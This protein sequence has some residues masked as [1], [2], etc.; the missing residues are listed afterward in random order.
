MIDIPLA[1]SLH[2]LGTETAFEVLARAKA[3]E[4]E[5][6]RIIHLQIGEPDFDTPPHVVE[7]AAQA[8]RDGHTHYCP[9]PGIPELREA[10]AA[11]LSRTRGIDVA[12]GRV[13]V[14]PGAKPFLFFGVLATCDPGDE[15]IYPN[16]GFPIYESVIRWAGCTPGAA[17][18]HRRARLRL[19]G[20]GRRRP[21]HRPHAADH[22][23]LAREPDRGR[24]RPRGRGRASP[25]CSPGTRAGSSPTR[26]TRRWSTRASTPRSRAAP[27]CSSARSCSTASRRPSR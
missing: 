21:S 5:G 10:A 6:R 7:T 14:T 9:A 3:L 19:H 4:A 18:A 8:L 24:P 25:R 13:L 23:Q 15:V 11:Y 16:P 26:S 1:Q 20:A 2:R 17:A 22:P 27:A 12:A